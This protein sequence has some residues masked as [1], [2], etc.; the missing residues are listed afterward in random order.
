MRI[1]VVANQKGGVGKSCISVSLAG[2]F[3]EAGRRPVIFDIN[4][5]QHT[6]A[7]WL[8]GNANGIEV[9]RCS[10]S[11]TRITY[12]LA[13]YRRRG[14]HGVAIVDTPPRAVAGLRAAA[15]VADT[16]LAPVTMSVG[17]M[18]P[19]A[20]MFR[21]P[22][23]FPADRRLVLNQ[24]HTSKTFMREV[25]GIAVLLGVPICRTTLGHRIAYSR[26]QLERLPVTAYEPEGKAA[27]EIRQLAQEIWHP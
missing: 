17:D 1:I 15:E 9:V 3:A 10:E 16:I 12:I 26:A 13:E 14:L 2:A 18:Q 11:D 5:P 20:D 19:V 21:L 23:K 27:A 22:I 4:D 25:R 8:G 7:A 24:T 6:A